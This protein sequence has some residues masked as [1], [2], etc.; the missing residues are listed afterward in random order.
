M[1]IIE[2]YDKNAIE[3]IASALLCNP[4]KVIFI[5]DNHK[6]MQKSIDIYSK[7]LEENDIH[8]ELAYKSVSKNRLQDIIDVLMET[9][10]EN[11]GCVFDLTG[12]ED[13]YLV[14]VGIVM[15]K[16]GGEIECHRFNFKNNTL[17]DCDADG[18]ICN[19]RSFD[20][21]VEDA[22]R[23]SGGVIV[24][25]T[26]KAVYTEGWCFNS[27]L[28]EDIGHMW[29][30]C[31]KN[32]RLWN[33]HIGCLRKICEMFDMPDYLTVCFDRRKAEAELRKCGIRYVCVPWIMTELEKYGLIRSLEMDESVS[34]FFKNEQIKRCL[35]VSGQVL[36]LAIA[37]KMLSLR[38]RDGKALY[39]DVMVGAVIDW[40]GNDRSEEIRT[41]NEIDVVAMKGAIP[42][43]ISCKNGDFDANEL[44]KLETVTDR[45]GG[46]YAKKILVSTELDKLGVKSE[47]LRARMHDMGIRSIENVD[48]DSDAE[49][50]RILRS[51]WCN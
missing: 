33:S 30:I 23:M 36:E 29:D 46:E 28:I 25:D 7:I 24:T 22:I 39:H 14:A 50:E 37:S 41:V 38:D 43:F 42:I 27:E 26:A 17:I 16:F 44:Y 48:E 45:F 11:E 6:K 20:I 8:T 19:T 5:G 49:L 9:V 10:S 18:N 12:G 15:E 51:L 31:R 2:F 1:T 40:D 47:Y 32:T 4:D 35:T 34:F 3:N 21:S 13:L